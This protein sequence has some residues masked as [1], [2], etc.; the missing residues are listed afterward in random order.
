M[1]QPKSKLGFIIVYIRL[2]AALKVA[3]LQQIIGCNQGFYNWFIP[4][5][6]W[7]IIWLINRT[8][9]PTSEKDPDEL[10][11]STLE[12]IR[13]RMGMDEEKFWKQVKER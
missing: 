6:L 11:W 5:F 7:A 4:P 12:A 1:K 3:Q 2:K 9:D 8:I 10:N 13:L